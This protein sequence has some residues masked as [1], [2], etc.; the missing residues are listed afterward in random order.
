MQRN[1]SDK[2]DFVK[3]PVNRRIIEHTRSTL[4]EK[5]DLKSDR[6]RPAKCGN[7]EK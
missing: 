5:M 3:Q 2:T 4:L 7:A 1:L 6:N